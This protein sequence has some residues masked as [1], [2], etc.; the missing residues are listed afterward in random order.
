[1][2]VGY[3]KKGKKSLYFKSGFFF[4]SFYLMI[5]I[6]IEDPKRL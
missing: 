4:M 1:M 6:V 5:W 3:Y 2:C